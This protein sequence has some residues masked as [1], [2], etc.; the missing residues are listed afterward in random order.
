MM[1]SGGWR[2]LKWTTWR[3]FPIRSLN[4]YAIGLPWE[5]SR[6]NENKVWWQ[7]FESKKRRSFFFTPRILL[8]EQ[9]V[10]FCYWHLTGVPWCGSWR[11]EECWKTPPGEFFSGGSLEQLSSQELARKDAGLSSLLEGLEVEISSLSA[12]LAQREAMVRQLGLSWKGK[13]ELDSKY[14]NNV[15]C[16]HLSGFEL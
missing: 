4:K 10:S 13:W 7:K 14:L 6:R 2:S 1:R 9:I 3:T 8:A 11:Y 16:F 15:V 12:C 5:A